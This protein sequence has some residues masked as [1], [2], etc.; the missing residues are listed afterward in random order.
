MRW[1]AGLWRSYRELS[2]RP[3]KLNKTITA[4]TKMQMAVI[5]SIPP[6]SDISL[7]DDG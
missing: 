6:G 2:E 1:Q 4:Q 3:V 7:F 5:I